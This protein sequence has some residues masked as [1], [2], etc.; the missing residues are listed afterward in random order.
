MKIGTKLNLLLTVVFISGILISGAALSSVLQQSAQEQVASKAMSLMEMV[1]SVR[2]Y[3]NTHVQPLLEPRLENQQ[4]FIPEAIPSFSVREVFENLRS[5]KEYTNYLYKDATLNPTNLRDQAD[6][7]ETKLV[8]RFRN[9]PGLQNLSGLRTLFGEKLFYSARPFVITEQSCLRCHSTVETAPKSMLATY[10][11]KN[12]FGWKLNEIFATQIIYVPADDVSDIAHR[13]V[14]VVMG[15]L[16]I[17]FAA[18]VLL[19]NLLLRKMVLQQIKKMSKVAQ[20]VSTGNM[21]S[22]FGKPSNDEIGALVLA[23]NR[24]KSSLE[25]A[26]NLLNHQTK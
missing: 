21:S 15:I 16:V 14:A 10:G 25:I 24:M 19:M 7:F 3:T 26:L 12:G 23:F 1:N 5:N 4:N 18:V 9:E 6:D 8:E 17:V 22:D 2:K 13:S 11:T 20:D